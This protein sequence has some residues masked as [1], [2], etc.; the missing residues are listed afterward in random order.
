MS[1]S[2][3]PLRIAMISYYL[4][5]GSKIG[6]G[7]Q[8]HELANELA[9]RGHR[10][11]MLSACP[12]VEGALYGHRELRL[13]GSLRT[14]RFAL[15]LRRVDYSGYDV[16]HAHGD[17]YWLWRRRVPVHVRTMHGT[18]FEEARRIPGF[19]EK[20]RMLLL[21]LTEVLASVVADV[22]VAVSPQ[23]R[24]WMPWVRRVIPNG[25][26]AGRFRPDPAKRSASPTIL[27]VGTWGNR[28]RGSALAHAFQRDV[29]PAL[30]DA[31]LEMVCR[32]APA[33]AGPGVVVLGAL[34]DA[35]LVQA[36]QRAWVFCLPSE[37]EGFGIP[38]AE[39]MACGLPVVAT[40]NVGARYVT[41]EGRAGVLSELDVIGAA[42]L[43]LLTDDAR[44]AELSIASADRA[45]AFTLSSVVDRYETLYRREG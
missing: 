31:R 10:V 12:P 23:T 25:V 22:T 9:R 16:I 37:Y 24:R 6:V 33:D 44:R 40:P 41:D 14:F 3:R 28:K 29:L 2:T 34:S 19:K 42:L 7:Y 18:G 1:A 39:A 27:F 35:E 5:S 32:D 17:D 8:A 45:H 36:Y 38:Y 15:A 30:P 26:D 4:P 43:R 11:D 21:G 13:A 20:L